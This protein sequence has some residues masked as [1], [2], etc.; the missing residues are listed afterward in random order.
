MERRSK[1]VR[2]VSGARAGD[3]GQHL[4]LAAVLVGAGQ[5]VVVGEHEQNLPGGQPSTEGR[6]L[7]V[8]VLRN[9]PRP[10]RERARMG[11][12]QHV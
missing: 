10:A 8:S 11:T 9:H 7:S 1:P 6:V 2:S 4:G 3:C 5:R 12:G